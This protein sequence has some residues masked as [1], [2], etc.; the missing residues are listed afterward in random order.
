[1]RATRAGVE[2]ATMT[3]IPGFIQPSRKAALAFLDGWECDIWNLRFRWNYG[4]IAGVLQPKTD[5]TRPDIGRY[6]IVVRL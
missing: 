2:N 4:I 1:M 5:V 3:I 6:D